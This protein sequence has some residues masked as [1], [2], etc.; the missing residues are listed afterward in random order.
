MKDKL[1]I[2][3]TAT[4]STTGN[5]CKKLEKLNFLYFL[6]CYHWK[7]S[8]QK[9]SKALFATFFCFV[10]SLLKYGLQIINSYRATYAIIVPVAES[11]KFSNFYVIV[12]YCVAFEIR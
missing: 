9:A 12:F 2:I 10:L 7:Y 6:L 4:Y 5:S 1:S 11:L 8:L 3:N